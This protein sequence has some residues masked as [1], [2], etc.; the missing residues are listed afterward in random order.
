VTKTPS[1]YDDGL[2]HFVVHFV[3]QIITLLN[4]ESSTL[5]LEA[6]R[7]LVKIANMLNDTNEIPRD[8]LSIITSDLQTGHDGFNTI[9]SY[10]ALLGSRFGIMIVPIISGLECYQC[11]P[12]WKVRSCT[13]IALSILILEHGPDFEH[14]HLPAIWN[15][16]FALNSIPLSQ[17]L[18]P[19]RVII[20]Q[21]LN[22]VAPLYASKDRS[23]GIAIANSLLRIPNKT[24]MEIKAIQS[25]ITTIFGA[26]FTQT[27]ESDDSL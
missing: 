3:V 17:K 10:F 13:N 22:N 5:R 18:F 21:A 9:M 4:H 8:K 1:A 11:D 25:C 12:D 20:I 15:F 2:E 19:D 6:A 27:K 24:Q 23:L 26:I 14:E 7:I 16:Y